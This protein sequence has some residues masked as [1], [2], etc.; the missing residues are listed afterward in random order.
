LFFFFFLPTYRADSSFFLFPPL[1]FFWCLAIWAFFLSQLFLSLIARPP[2]PLVLSLRG[3]RFLFFSFA[4]CPSRHA[5]FLTT[6]MFPRELKRFSLS[7]TFLVFPARCDPGPAFKKVPPVPRDPG[8][9]LFLSSCHSRPS[10]LG[11]LTPA[12]LFCPSSAR[13]ARSFFPR[14]LP[15]SRVLETCRVPLPFGLFLFLLCMRSPGFLHVPP[16]SCRLLVL[17]DT[18]SF[19]GGHGTPLCPPAFKTLFFHQL[20]RLSCEFSRFPMRGRWIESSFHRFPGKTLFPLGVCSLLCFTRCGAG[21]MTPGYARS[22]CLIYPPPRSTAPGFFFRLAACLFSSHFCPQGI[23]FGWH[24]V[25][26]NGRAPLLVLIGVPHSG[27]LYLRRKVVNRTVPHSL[28]EHIVVCHFVLCSCG[29]GWKA[30]LCPLPTC[31]S[32]C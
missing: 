16:P 25:A 12:S 14:A 30:F 15:C 6:P 18:L 17:T 3:S 2:P 27:C 24:P 9:F 10:S 8:F 21:R 11:P 20:G 32:S 23:P 28:D 26:V 1:L 29:G 13:I 5:P 22:F 19:T 4:D 31:C 7:P